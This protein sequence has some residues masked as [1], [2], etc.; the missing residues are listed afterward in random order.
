MELAPEQTDAWLKLGWA[1]YALEDWED[2]MIAGQRAIEVHGRGGYPNVWLLLGLSQGRRGDLFE[3]RA[4]FEKA[5]RV[6]KRKSKGGEIVPI[7]RR[8][9][10]ELA[11]LLGL[12]A[13]LP[14]DAPS[15]LDEQETFYR[16]AVASGEELVAGYPLVP[17]FQADLASHHRDLANALLKLGKAEEA[18][19]SL[20]RSR[21]LLEA[22]VDRYPHHADYRT[23][24]LS[25]AQGFLSQPPYA[26]LHDPEWVLDVARRAVELGPED[27]GSWQW[28]GLA[29]YR[30]GHWDAAIAATERC[31]ELRGGPPE[32]FHALILALAHGQKG[33]LE[34]ARSWYDR[35]VERI[36]RSRKEEGY[37]TEPIVKSFLDEAEAL[38]GL[39]RD[40]DRTAPDP[41]HEAK[42]PPG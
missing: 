28:L 36:E 1:R 17:R 30:N 26:Q 22:L 42:E 39:S 23:G 27:Q 35:A 32:E 25:L 4:W 15:R 7:M 24:H 3:A 13:P 5:Y 11:A 12:D 31:I 14:G 16:A 40:S 29:E 18:K 2:A 33:D 10:A 34:R 20:E 37:R 8:H 38:L 21:A 9:H 6:Q 19:A 41:P